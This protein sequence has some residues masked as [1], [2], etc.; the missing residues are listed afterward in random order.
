MRGLARAMSPA[1]SRP[2]LVLDDHLEPNLVASLAE[3]IVEPHDLVR[4]HHFRKH[5]RGRGR[6][7]G[8]NRL[9]V[10]EPH[11]ASR[12][13]DAHDALDAVL[14]LGSGEE[15]ERVAAGLVLVLGRDAVLEL[16]ADD[17]RSRGERLRKAVGAERGREDEAAA[18]AGRRYGLSGHG[19]SPWRS[20][21]HRPDPNR[22]HRI[23]ADREPCPGEARRGALV[24]RIRVVAHAARPAGR[25]RFTIEPRSASGRELVGVTG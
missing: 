18:R 14:G 10:G 17:V 11:R 4:G 16:H 6:I 23:A 8:E 7:R 20:G 24:Y 22:L 1:A 5:E 12:A 9:H 2:A 21:P 19:S 13:V 25:P 15:G 3:E